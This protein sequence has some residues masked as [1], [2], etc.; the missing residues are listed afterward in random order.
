M[1]IVVC[2]HRQILVCFVG[3][4]SDG[5]GDKMEL[6]IDS[7]LTGIAYLPDATIRKLITRRRQS[8]KHLIRRQSWSPVI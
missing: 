1:R 2:G 6:Y 3:G 4:R 5:F 8:F 7:Y